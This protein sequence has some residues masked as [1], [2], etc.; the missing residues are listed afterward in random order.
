VHPKN[1]PL[2]SGSV[3]PPKKMGDISPFAYKGVLQCY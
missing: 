3:H 2:F 1:I